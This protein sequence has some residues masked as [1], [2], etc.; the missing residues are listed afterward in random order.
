VVLLD[1]TMPQ[2]G[3]AEVSRLLAELLM[4]HLPAVGYVPPPASYLA[5][6]DCTALGLGDDP[7][8]HVLAHGRVA[9]SRGLVHITEADLS[10]LWETTTRGG[11]AILVRHDRGA[12]RSVTPIQDRD[13]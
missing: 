7:A 3:G 11:G 13:V 5:W 10:A 6:L 12:G 1:L 2:M 8:A 4:T 9:L